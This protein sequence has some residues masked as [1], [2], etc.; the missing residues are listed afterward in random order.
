MDERFTGTE[1]DAAGGAR[2]PFAGRGRRGTRARGRFADRGEGPAADAG[3]TAGP[4]A[5]ADDAGSAG[6]DV[7]PLVAEVAALLDTLGDAQLVAVMDAC[8]TRLTD[9]RFRAPT[10]GEQLALVT[11]GIRAGARLSAWTHLLAARA[12]AGQAAWN[13]YKTSTSTWLMGTLRFTHTEATRMIKHGD[14]LTRFPQLADAAKAGVVLPQ[15]AEAITRVLA[16]LPVD[17]PAEAVTRG[18]VTMVELAG[19]HTSRELRALT[20][21]LVEVLDPATA[22]AREAVRLERAHALAVRTRH[23]EFHRDGQTTWFRGSLP[24]DQADV[25]IRLIDAY[26]HYQRGLDTLDPQAEYVT[27]SMRRADA[28]T[29]L[30]NHHTQQALA[31]GHGGDR[32]R[33]VVTMSYDKL[34]KHAHDHHLTGPTGHLIGSGEAVPAGVLRQL[35]CDADLMPIVLGG[36]SE[37]LDVGRTQRLVTPAIRAALEIRDGSCVFPGCDKPPQACHAHHITPW[38]ASGT[39]TLANLVLVCPHHHGIIEPSRHHDPTTGPDPTRWTIRINTH[40]IPEL[41]PPHH[42]DP[43]QTPRTHTRFHTPHRT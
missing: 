17:V 21:H 3:A 42:I 22:E 7:D 12:D 32:P 27:P 35:L 38:W 14:A 15:Q 6:P 11:A 43:H 10:D 9:D 39:T 24:T 26:T 1:G 31:P 8:L 28:L 5:D 40:G 37:P 16:D 30:L 25:F 34:A 13:E 36:T 23:L 33:I 18:E 29:A 19:T 41:I 20:S 2:E 4:K